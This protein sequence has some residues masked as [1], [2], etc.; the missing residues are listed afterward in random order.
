MTT[1]THDI[2]N[3]PPWT[4]MDI[5]DLKAA[6]EN[7][8]SVQDA[9]EFHRRSD[10]IDD[11]RQKCE[12]LGLKVRVGSRASPQGFRTPHPTL[13]MAF[14]TW[15]RIDFATGLDRLHNSRKTGSVTRCTDNFCNPLFWLRSFH[16][17]GFLK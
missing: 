16:E 4:D 12:E 17:I 7:G 11:V 10:S 6:I 2:Y 8:R 5:D 9:A 3:N 14:L 13:S 1:T 15:C